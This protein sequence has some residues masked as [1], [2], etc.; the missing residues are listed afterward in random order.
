MVELN[1]PLRVAISVV[2]PSQQ[3][4]WPLSAQ[5]Y[6]AVLARERG[7]VVAVLLWR[8]YLC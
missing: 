7:V 2:P 4:I 8:T 6:A 3:G 5:L 1:R